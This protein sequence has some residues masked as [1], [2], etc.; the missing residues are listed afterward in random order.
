MAGAGIGETERL[1]VT[2]LM[3]DI[4]GYSTI[5][6]RADP[7]ALPPSSTSTGPR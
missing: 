3:S 5:A 4:R 1:E 2:V 6:E 7:S